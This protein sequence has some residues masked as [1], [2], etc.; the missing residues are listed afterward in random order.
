MRFSAKSNSA[1][2]AIERLFLHMN[3]VDVPS[4]NLTSFEVT[5]TFAAMKFSLALMKLAGV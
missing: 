2:V 5:S 1:E 4:Q 3:I